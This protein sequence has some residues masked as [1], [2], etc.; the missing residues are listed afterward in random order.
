MVV[1][2]P[3]WTILKSPFFSAPRFVNDALD[4]MHAQSS[5]LSDP[6]RPNQSIQPTL[7][8]G[9]LRLRRTVKTV[10]IHRQGVGTR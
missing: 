5:H 3:P 9:P 4:S 2:F 7:A 6:F 1:A 8:L 10:R